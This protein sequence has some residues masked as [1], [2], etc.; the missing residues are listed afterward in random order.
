MG[1]SPWMLIVVVAGVL[2]V[3]LGGIKLLERHDRKR[4]ERKR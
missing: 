1:F 2:G 3:A 4:Q